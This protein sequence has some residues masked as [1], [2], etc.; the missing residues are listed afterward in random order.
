M[1]DSQNEL[2]TLGQWISEWLGFQLP[3]IPLPQTLKN[4]DKALGIL[5][6]AGIENLEA[7]IKNNTEKKKARGKIELDA[8]YKTAEEK[9]KLENRAA[10]AK[11]ALDELEE[12]PATE[13]AKAE[14]DNDW[15]NMFT[16]LAEDKSSEELQRLF[17][18]ILA[19]EIMRP[20]SFS[21]RTLQSVS[22]LSKT[23][24]EAISK[25]LPYVLGDKIVAF[26]GTEPEIDL[27][28]R[29]QMDELGVAGNPSELS[30]I[31]IRAT[32]QPS[33]AAILTGLGNGVIV[34]QNLSQKEIA[35][36]V[37][38]QPITKLGLELRSIATLQDTPM[39][40]LQ[41]VSDSTYKYLKKTYP[42]EV[43]AK[44]VVVFVGTLMPREA[45]RE[46][47]PVYDPASIA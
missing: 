7:G 40:Y 8:M 15:L 5:I 44:Q 43:K 10:A 47:V 3:S 19:G 27:A 16:R 12:N 29:M 26:V 6:L 25:F 31:Q 2:P 36:G 33:G 18:R 42:E 9:R 1:S 41:A 39:P 35:Y 30:G 22:A 21:L 24:A 37:G 20:G 28:L 11:A 17:G 14:I 4:T 45:G 13:D 34:V 46:I 38:G 23:E 32:L